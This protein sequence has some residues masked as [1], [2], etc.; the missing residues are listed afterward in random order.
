[1][2]Y[3]VNYFTDPKNEIIAGLYL[4]S[5]KALEPSNLLGI[6][7]VIS[8]TDSA[9]SYNLKK[10]VTSH[11]VFPVRDSSS[12]QD[13]MNRVKKYIIMIIKNNLKQNKT[14]LVHC[15]AGLHRAA[16]IVVYY[17]KSIGFTTDQALECVQSKRPLALWRKP[18]SLD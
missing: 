2:A 3:I 15:D 10:L 6:D 1:M 8:L 18:F 5:L 17:L 4:G 16:T 12:D 9:F 14:V 13:T 11:Y 7:T